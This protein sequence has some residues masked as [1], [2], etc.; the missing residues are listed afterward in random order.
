MTLHQIGRYRSEAEVDQTLNPAHA[1]DSDLG[2]V[3]T[4]ACEER[5]ELFSQIVFFQ[6]S[7][8]ANMFFKL[9]KS[10]R[11]F[12]LKFQFR[13]FHTAKTLS[14]PR[15]LTNNHHIV[16]FTRPFLGAGDSSHWL[17]EIVS[18]Q[19]ASANTNARANVQPKMS[20]LRR[21]SQSGK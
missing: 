3:K 1:V 10:R 15:P 12:Y 8:Q 18:S 14:R 20:L 5:A 13:S 7:W 21:A 11:T 2:C 4:S 17:N 6:E 9:T 19:I 16:S